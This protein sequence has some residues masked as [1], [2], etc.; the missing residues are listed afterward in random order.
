[1]KSILSL[2]CLLLLALNGYTQSGSQNF[3]L[4]RVYRQT[5][6]GANDVSKVDIKVEY[7][8]GLGRPSQSV[9]VGQSPAGR[10]IVTPVV[11]DAYG[12]QPNQYLP[13]TVSGG[14][15]A[16][17]SGAVSA[18]NSFYTTNIP[19]LQPGDLSRPYR[20]TTFE[21]SPLNRPT[22]VR[23]PGNSS[24]AAITA[25]GSNS[26]NEVKRYTYSAN[27]DIT[28]T[29]ADQGY[30]PANRLYRTQ[31]TDEEGK[32]TVGF[33]D[34]Q[35]R[36][37]CRKANT[38]SESLDTYYV[39]DDFGLLRAVLQ[40]EYQQSA[41][42]AD[43]AFLYRYDGRGRVIEKKVPGAGVVR[44][45]YDIYDRLALS[46]DANQLARGVWGFTKYD[47]F[48]RPVM[49]GEL[50]SSATRDS[51]QGTLNGSTAHHENPTTTG[52]GYTLTTTQPTGISESNVLTVTHYDNYS[53]PKPSALDY[54]NT[55]SVTPLTNV[56]TH[57]T[58][59]RARMLNSG[60]DWL[61]SVTYYDAEYRPVQ[62][63]RQL[64]DLASG[65]ERISTKYLHDLASLVDEEK[66]VQVMGPVTHSLT[67]SYEYDH[68][69]RQLSVNEAVTS[70]SNS[71]AV[72]T[73][74]HRYN[75]LGQPKEKWLHSYN[76]S[77]YSRRT[78]YTHNIR[79]WLT[80]GQT[81]YRPYISS[82]D[83]PFYGFEL[84]YSNGSYYTNGNISRMRWKGKDATTFSTGLDF[85]YDGVNRL[86]GGTGTGGYTHTES[87]I[88]YDRNGNIKTF[89]RAGSA[90]DNLTYAYSGNR[91]TSISDVSGNSSGVKS[92]TSNYTHDGNGN[93]LTDGNRNATLTYNYLNLP[94][95]V[96]IG[97][98]V[99]TYD[100]DAS[101]I[102]HKYATHVATMKYAG[103]FEYD[104]SSNLKRVA[105]TD[106]QVVYHA[107]TL[108]FD[109]YLKDHL[110]NGR[111]VFDE[112]REV[113]QETEYYAFGLTIPRTGTD[114]VNKYQY[115][116]KEKQL[117][118]GY[119]DYGARM[120]DPT[121]GRWGAVDPLADKYF[122]LSPF[123]YVANNPLKYI[124]PDGKE[125]YLVVSRDHNQKGELVLKYQNRKFYNLDGSEYKSGPLTGFSNRVREAFNNI[126]D[127]D[128]YLEKIISTLE[129]TKNPHIIEFSR[130]VSSGVTGND[131]SIDPRSSMATIKFSDVSKTLGSGEKANLETTMTHEL[132]HQYDRE[133]GKLNRNV[134]IND[135][136][137]ERDPNEIRA[138]N[139]ENRYRVNN[140]MELRTHYGGKIDPKRLEDPKQ[141][142]D[143]I[144]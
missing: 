25:Y 103:P 6:A 11:Y 85:T 17:Q 43:F 88:T 1:M 55:Y 35:G 39:Y 33:T 133:K 18:Q 97:S 76:G 44:M 102:K 26:A 48:N 141:K 89:N 23:E 10:D 47:A 79:G 31:N 115:N 101:G 34:I 12:R 111:V 143:E 29:I 130:K 94:K 2:L 142:K 49:T 16:F 71:K 86:T 53:F 117:E 68:A 120:Y 121:I 63:V 24:Q 40:P 4:S 13:Y 7:F 95:T 74:A 75:E 36:T 81:Q 108:R 42:A 15:G 98:N 73:V 21:S 27:S 114:A 109:Y 22:G 65:T 83:T 46:Q 67:K 140:N 107:D 93:M 50:T 118:T 100:Y 110:G 96:T 124:D 70:G 138:V 87:G 135:K 116:G 60:G 38:G 90:S 99:M 134:N 128:S 78:D 131:A 106:G 32:V 59:S 51:W 54:Q 28:Q 125:I 136:G 127:S 19:G 129:S 20:E 119:L 30:Y 37:V 62:T 84:T 3:V 52:I 58:G 41:V 112:S 104:G 82:P 66:T 139:V 91:L 122:D 14:N 132:S 45:V 56:K 113:Q 9:A 69:G 5:G 123:S 105:I 61:V 77:Q 137:T 57:P 64:Y 92:G 126:R 144:D 80:L 8:D 72:F